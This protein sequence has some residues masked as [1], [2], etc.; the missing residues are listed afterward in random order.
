[1]EAMLKNISAAAGEQ[2]R[3]E[4]DRCSGGKGREGGSYWVVMGERR[5]GD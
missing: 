2:W 1:M 4:S 5:K 3:Q